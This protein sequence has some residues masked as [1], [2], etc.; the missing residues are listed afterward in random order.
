MDCVTLAGDQVNRHGALRGGYVDEKASRLGSYIKMC[1]AQEAL[2]AKEQQKEAVDE[3]VMAISQKLTVATGELQ[4]LE[5]QRGEARSAY[6]RLQH[7]LA[8]VQVCVF[9]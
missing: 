3:E 6:K 5:S 1:V 7:E 9:V 4:K 8:K 2:E